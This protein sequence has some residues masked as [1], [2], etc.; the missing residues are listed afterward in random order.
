MQVKTTISYY[1][2]S[3]RMAIIN[4]STNINVGKRVE[5]RE[6]SFTLCGKEVDAATMESSME[7]P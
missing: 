3:V 7:I 4:K 1:L 6:A 5:Q 2:I